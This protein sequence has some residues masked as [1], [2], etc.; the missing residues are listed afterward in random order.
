MKGL[1]QAVVFSA[2]LMNK[3]IMVLIKRDTFLPKYNLKRVGYTRIMAHDENGICDVGDR[4][5]LKK[6]EHSKRKHWEVVEML[7]K[8]PGAKFLQENPQFKSL[9]QHRIAAKK[10]LR[11][12]RKTKTTTHSAER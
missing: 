6:A 11:D 7:K 10:K 2:R 4:V 8:E 9:D 3:S 12:E 1:V 5:L